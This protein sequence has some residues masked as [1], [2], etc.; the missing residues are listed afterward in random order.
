MLHLFIYHQCHIFTVQKKK[1]KDEEKR[2]KEEAALRFLF[3]GFSSLF[4]NNGKT[5]IMLLFIVQRL[6]NID[7]RR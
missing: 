6:L 4:Q 2:R 1:E 5:L 7:G 3:L